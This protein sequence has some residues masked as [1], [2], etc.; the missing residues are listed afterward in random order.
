MPISL[1][2][3]GLNQLQHELDEP[4]NVQLL[5][6]ILIIRTIKGAKNLTLKCLLQVY[7]IQTHIL[8]QPQTTFL[9]LLSGKEGNT[10]FPNTTAGSLNPI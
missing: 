2:K 4:Q 8:Y 1:I 3:F 6:E 7:Q 5:N 10:R 9:T